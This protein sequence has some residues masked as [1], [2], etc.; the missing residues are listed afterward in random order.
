MEQDRESDKQSVADNLVPNAHDAPF[1]QRYRRA[2]DN[3]QLGNNLLRFQ[4][5]WRVSRDDALT[6]YDANPERAVVASAPHPAGHLPRAT[7]TNEFV[8]LRD[9]LAAIK[10]EMIDHLPEY[11]DQ[12]QQAAEARGVHVYRAADAAA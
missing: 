10:N 2:L 12:F 9:R 5:S 7:G 1:A 3:A 6:A 4:R 11:L 8:A